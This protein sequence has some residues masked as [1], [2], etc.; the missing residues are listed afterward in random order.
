[1]DELVGMKRARLVQ[2]VV[3]V[4]LQSGLGPVLPIPPLR[5]QDPRET[6]L[7]PH[8]LPGSLSG[9]NPSTRSRFGVVLQLGAGHSGRPPVH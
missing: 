6:S 7:P 4:R 8:I 5:W 9:H 2:E 1:M 3:Q